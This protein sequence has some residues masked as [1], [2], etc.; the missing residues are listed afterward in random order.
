ME[1]NILVT[2][3]GKGIPLHMVSSN[4]RE[5]VLE[6]DLERAWNELGFDS[7]WSNAVPVEI[8]IL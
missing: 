5:P 6:I 1:D 2:I 4:A 7:R 3:L 8:V